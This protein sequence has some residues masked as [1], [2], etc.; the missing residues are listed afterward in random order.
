MRRLNPQER[1]AF[2]PVLAKYDPM[3]DAIPMPERFAPIPIAKV[4]ATAASASAGVSA[5]AVVHEDEAVGDT[6]DVGTPR[7]AG[8]AQVP[9]DGA[10]QKPGGSAVY[11]SD[12]ELLEAQSATDDGEVEE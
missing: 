3:L 12:K 5:P 7:Q 6:E 2:K 11:L 9:P 1:E 10:P 8:P 4:D